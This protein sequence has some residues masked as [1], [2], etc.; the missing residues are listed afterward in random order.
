MTRILITGVCGFTGSSLAATLLQ[1]SGDFTV[2][3]IDN[4]MRP[5]SETNRARLSRMGVTFVH[6]DVRSAS[7]FEQLPAADWV[8]DAAAIP[9][10]LGGVS[11]HGSSR[12]I[13]EHNL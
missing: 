10:V 13:M 11:G 8:I 9:N 12:Q 7:D 3:G 5:G 1:H 4:L 2:Y 6:G